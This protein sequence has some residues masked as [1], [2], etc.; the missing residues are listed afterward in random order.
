MARQASL[1]LG[2]TNSGYKFGIQTPTP[3]FGH[4][5]SYTRAHNSGHKF[6]IQTPILGHTNSGYKLGI[7]TPILG[8]TNSGYKFGIQTPILGRTNSGYK[9]LYSGI[10]T[11]ILG[12]ANFQAFLMLRPGLLDYRDTSY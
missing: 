12:H 9:L 4:T 10:Q 11:P 1:Q 5:N 2:H 6:G 7:Q 8:H 3:I